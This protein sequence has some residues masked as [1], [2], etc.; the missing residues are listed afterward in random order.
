MATTMP[1]TATSRPSRAGGNASCWKWAARRPVVE[2]ARMPAE[3]K[4]ASALTP[5]LTPA[6][7][8]REREEVR[9]PATARAA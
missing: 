7:S 3:R 2:K 4:A 1:V 5:A 6:L 8:E 9:R